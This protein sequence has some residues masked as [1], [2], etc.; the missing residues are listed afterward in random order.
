M[1]TTYKIIGLIIVCLAASYAFVWP[2]QISGD[3]MEPA[4]QDG[5]WYFLN[6]GLPY[7]RHYRSGD[8]ILF[9]YEDKTWIARI[10]GM[11]NDTVE[12]TQDKIMV[13]DSITQDTIERN[14]NNWNWGTYAI[15][16]PFKVPADSVYVLSDNLSAHHDDSRVFGPISVKS[17][18]GIVW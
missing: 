15:E 6:R 18:F 11:A 17:I 12:I 16:K 10:V 2:F 4:I 9:D 3:C 5:K 14:W 1:K 8:I 7:L 13:N